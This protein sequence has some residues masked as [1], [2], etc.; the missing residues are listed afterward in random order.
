MN[1]VEKFLTTLG[2]LDTE[3][4]GT[5]SIDDIIQLSIMMN[6]QGSHTYYTAMYK[7]TM[8]IPAE[9]SAVHFIS[10]EDVQ[11]ESAFKDDARAVGTLLDNFEYIIA[12]NAE[13]D[14]QMLVNNFSRHHGT[15]PA[16][17][18]NVTK[19]IC[20]LKLAKKLYGQDLA[21]FSNMKLGYLWFKLGLN[22]LSDHKVQPHDA[23][24]DVYMCYK[25]L[26][27]LVHEC[28]NRGIVDP[29]GDVGQQLY[30]FS[31]TPNILEYYPYG[32]YKG[33]KFEVVATKDRRYLEWMVT[34]SDLLN[35]QL[36]S[37]DAD[38][39]ETVAYYLSK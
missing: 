20:T 30:K 39:A 10:D 7:P 21:N 23:Q 19:W 9:S 8:P 28:I 3:T 38:F 6:F 1:N 36:P 11:N 14:R 18:L 12:H 25:L 31:N 34:T 2:T 26:D 32:K 33:E 13:F 4:T 16:N 15:I 29:N 27:F 17:V 37:F 24:D 5:E 22:K 35:D